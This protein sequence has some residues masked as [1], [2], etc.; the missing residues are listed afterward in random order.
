MRNKISD[1][2]ML[3]NKQLKEDLK[4]TFSQILPNAIEVCMRSTFVE[5]TDQ[6]ENLCSEFAERF[7]AMVSDQL[8]E[9]LADI[10]DQYLKSAC[11]YGNIITTGSAVMQTAKLNPG[12]VLSVGN[13][14]AG[15][16]PN[17]LGIK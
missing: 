1:N 11:I 17:I 6:T 9:R 2:L 12:G 13:P 10:I 5:M 14:F 7:D 8:A 4:N 3:N 15:K 16:L